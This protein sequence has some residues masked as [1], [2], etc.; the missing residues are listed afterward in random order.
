MIAQNNRSFLQCDYKRECDTHKRLVITWN[1][2]VPQAIKCAFFRNL[3]SKLFFKLFT[4]LFHLN[5]V[6]K[7]T[8]LVFSIH[9]YEDN[10]AICREQP[11]LDLVILVFVLS[12]TLKEIG[13]NV[14]K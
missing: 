13:S 12:K 2:I 5:N 4:L 10:S 1:T 11:Y 3:Y 8:N 14:K 7:I 9:F 6:W